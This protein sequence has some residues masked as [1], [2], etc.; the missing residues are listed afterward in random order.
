MSIQ[1]IAKKYGMTAR[2]IYF[3]LQEIADENHVTRDELLFVPQKPHIIKSVSKKLSKD[4]MSHEELKKDFTFGKIEI[5]SK[6]SDVDVYK[7]LFKLED[8]PM[9]EA[10]VMHH[11]YGFSIC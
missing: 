5:V 2:N 7:Y 11:D 10:V 8:T 6:L 3:H 9:V 4:A 1:D